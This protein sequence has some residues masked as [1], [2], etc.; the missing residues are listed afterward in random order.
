MPGGYR[1]YSPLAAGHFLGAFMLIHTTIASGAAI[2]AD[3]DCSAWGRL[4]AVTVPTVTSGDLL[5]QGSFDSTSANF[6]RFLETRGAPVSGDLR[7]A[8]GPGSR[9]AVLSP[10]LD[11]TPFLRLELSATQADTRTLTLLVRG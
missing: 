3:I 4:I 7:L 10:P 2:S 9:M 11:I 5:I 8:T 1:R 6:R